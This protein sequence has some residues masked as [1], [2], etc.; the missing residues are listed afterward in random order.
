MLAK[1]LALF[2]RK[3]LD[4]ETMAGLLAYAGLIREALAALESYL[5]ERNDKR[6]L[7]L[8]RKLHTLLAEMI[9]QHGPTVGADVVAFS[10][11]GPKN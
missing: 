1:L 10:G 6:G 9:E 7:V 2:K 3:P 11:G 5:E 4:A 8:V